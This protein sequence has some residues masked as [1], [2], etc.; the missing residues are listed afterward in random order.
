M[1]ESMNGL[2]FLRKLKRE[3]GQE[4]QG[5][6]QFTKFMDMKAREKG[7]P[8]IGQFE[9]T[10][11]CNFSCK[12]C[13]VHLTPEQM[14]ERKPLP[15]ETWKDLMRQAWEA[16]MVYATLTGGECLAYPGFDELYLYLQE[17]GC[18]VHILTNGY[19]LDEKRIRFFREHKPRSIQV[20]LYGWNDDV[21]ERVTGQRAF[22]TVSENV[23]KAVEAGLHV[24]ICVTPSEFLGEDVLET[25]RTGK[26]LGNELIVNNGLFVPREET[27][28]AG[29]DHLDN[30]ETYIRIYRMLREMDGIE[31]A[32]I[33]EGKLPP[34]GGPCHECTAY[35]LRCGGGRSNFVVDWKGTLMP[36]NRLEMIR[37]FPLEAGF[38]AAW[39]AINREANAWPRVPECEGCPYD[40][41]CN[42]CAGAMIMYAKPGKQPIGLC[43][44]TKCYVRHGV[45]HI[46]E[47]D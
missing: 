6:S 41:V 46:P 15:V 19:L 11:L 26:S 37:S 18:E 28:R 39:E 32:G 30:I 3:N 1:N 29:L 40:S 13:Y 17:L 43:E 21:Y 42:N 47:C 33:D 35:G 4:S 25:V 23:R 9:L 12:M 8:M 38:L 16:G 20:T 45:F 27:G 2:E 22:R 5:F 44:Q 24:K 7:I 36:C 34:A 14:T 31:T 10:P